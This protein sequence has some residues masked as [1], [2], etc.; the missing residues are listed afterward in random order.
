MPILIKQSEST[1]T[2]KSVPFACVDAAD[3]Y[4]PETGLTFAAADIKIKKPGVAETNSAGTVTEVG[5]GV[6]EYYPTSSELDTVGILHVAVDKSGV[7]PS[8]SI[9]Q[10][11]PWDPFNATSLGLGNLTNAVMSPAQ[12]ASAVLTEANGVETGYTVQSTLRLVAS[13]LLGRLSGAGTGT[14]VFRDINNTK[15]RVTASIDAN[16][17]RTNISLDPF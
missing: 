11:V 12:T 3:G 2:R 8:V 4:T 10:I 13:V 9:A 7:R 5:R 1:N 15:S 16:N 17:N 14:E 6:Y